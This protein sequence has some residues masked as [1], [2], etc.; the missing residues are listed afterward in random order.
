VRKYALILVV[1]LLGGLM[2]GGCSKKDEKKEAPQTGEAGQ[3]TKKETVVKVPEIVQGKWK[4]VKIAVQDKTTNKETVYTVDIGGQLS[5]P[6]SDLTLKVESFLPHFIMEGATLTSQTNEPK[7]PAVQIKIY[8]AGKEVFKGWLFTLY[9]TTHAF[10]NPKYS[11]SL[12]DFVP[13]GK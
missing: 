7:N 2:A 4:A 10:Q 1:A 6:G 12:V 9:P 5:L 8:Q 3:V 13:A 11:F